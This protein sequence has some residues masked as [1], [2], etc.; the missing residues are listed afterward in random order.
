MYT[1]PCD[2][3][4]LPDIDADDAPEDVLKLQEAINTAVMV[5]W[6]LTGRQF[7]IEDVTARPCPKERDLEDYALGGPIGFV[8]LLVDGQWQ[9]WTGCAGGGCTADGRGVVELPGPVVSITEILVDGVAIA[10]DGYVL[11]GNLLYRVAGGEWPTQDLTIPPGSPGTWTVRYLRGNPPPA[12]AAAMVGQLALEF[13][14]MCNGGKCRLPKRW[15]SVT[16]QGVSIVRADP[17]DILA[18][19]YT[20]IPEIDMWTTALNPDRLRQ[21]SAI[22]SPDYSSVAR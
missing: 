8:P 19:G 1:W 17:T 18:Q 7:A 21:P 6:S 2:R 4:C 10:S 11:D 15:Q 16:R 22:M 12:G 5:L 3:S 14:N 20:G 13:W 9:N